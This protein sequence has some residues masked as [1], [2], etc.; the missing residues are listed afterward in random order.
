ML[1]V[2]WPYQSFSLQGG[3]RLQG[4]IGSYGHIYR[5]YFKK[6]IDEEIMGAQGSQS[7][8]IFG[9]VTGQTNR[10]FLLN[11]ASGQ[12]EWFDTL[13]EQ[14]LRLTKLQCPRPVMNREVHLVSLRTKF[15]DFSR[16]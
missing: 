12:I 8:I 1:L 11:T 2:A 4:W 13:S 6:V 5:G 9:W 16:N 14:A 15:R 10:Y 7:G 3:Y